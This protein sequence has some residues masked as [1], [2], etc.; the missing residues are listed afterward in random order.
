VAPTPRPT[1][2][3]VTIKIKHRF[4]SNYEWNDDYND[5]R[6]ATFKAFDTYIKDIL[7]KSFGYPSNPEYPPSSFTITPIAPSRKRR[8]VN[9]DGFDFD[10]LTTKTILFSMDADNAA[11]DEAATAIAGGLTAALSYISHFDTDNVITGDASL[12]ST[13]AETV[14]CYINN[15]GCSHTCDRS[16]EQ[17]YCRCPS[18][19]EM[20]DDQFN[21]RPMS[22]KIQTQCHSNAMEITLHKCV[23]AD[24]HDF[25][26]ARM[27]DGDCAFKKNDDQLTVTMTNPLGECGMQLD[28]ENGQII[29]SNKMTI[30]ASKFEGR[31]VTTPAIDWG[32]TCIYETDYTV[33]KAATV[34]SATLNHDFGAQTGQFA[35]D[36]KF[37][38]SESFEIVQDN[39]TYKVGQ[40]IFFGL[41]MNDNIKLDK[42]EFA[43]TDCT[44]SAGDYSFQIWDYSNLNQ[45]LPDKYIG[46]THYPTTDAFAKFSYEGFQ[47]RP[48]GG[49]TP[50]EQTISC[51][52]KVCHED[53]EDSACKNG[54]YGV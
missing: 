48:D 31:I 40:Q 28:Y 43:A 49:S 24:S 9:G 52:V 44:V 50:P 8:A 51:A 47:F 20:S 16:G 25:T 32:F 11:I 19:W 33:E 46:F 23:L 1:S 17:H 42:L 4:T 30:D 22:D 18:C 12:V 7:S 2:K 5:P 36:F 34:T 35:F 3:P 39:P 54:C 38:E 45:C 15:G 14:D 10:V 37:Y 21:C 29:Y 26:T 41:I 13:A 6:S 53:D 27:S